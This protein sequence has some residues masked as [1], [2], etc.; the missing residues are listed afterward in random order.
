MGVFASSRRICKSEG[1]VLLPV[2]VKSFG[3]MTREFDTAQNAT[4]SVSMDL[5]RFSVAATTPEIRAFKTMGAMRAW[6]SQSDGN[7]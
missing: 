7:I 2:T 3:M 4:A 5:E 6:R 1:N